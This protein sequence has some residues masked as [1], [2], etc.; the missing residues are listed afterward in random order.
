M[1]VEADQ[2]VG[3]AQDMAHRAV[4]LLQLDDLELGEI[5]LQS[6]QILRPRSAPGV[7]RLVVV[8]DRGEAAGRTDELTHELVL[9]AVGVLVLVDE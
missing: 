1:R 3:R 8:A 9:G 4:V 7:D 5:A 6:G 2:V